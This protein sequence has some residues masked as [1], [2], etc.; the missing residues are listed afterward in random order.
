MAIKDFIIGVLIVSIFT[1]ALISTGVNIG[2]YNDQAN[3]LLNESLIRETYS[4]LNNSFKY[5]SDRFNETKNSF[6]S[7]SPLVF[8]DSII[9]GSIVNSGKTATNVTFSMIIIVGNLV[10]KQLG[11]PPVIMAVIFAIITIVI[12]LLIWSLIRTGT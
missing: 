2:L 1:F 5:S 11:I 6:E 12:V 4:N 8:G 7:D 3:S 10:E 9:L